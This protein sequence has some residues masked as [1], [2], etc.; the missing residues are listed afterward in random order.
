MLKVKAVTAFVPL[1]VQNL[2]AGEYKAL[3]DQLVEAVGHDNI[4]VFNDFPFEA[5]T[6]FG[7]AD[8][9]HIDPRDYPDRYARKLDMS[10]SS[11][12]QHNRTSWAMIASQ[13]QPD[14][15][16]WVWLDYGV[17]K[18]GAFTGRPV[19]AASIRDFMA[20]VAHG[21][22]DDVPY[23]GIWEERQV[24]DQD[25]N[26]RFC[27]STHI[28]PKRHLEAIH[29]TYLTEVELFLQRTGCLPYDMT[30]WAAVERTGCAPFRQYRANH[31]N[32]QFSNFTPLTGRTPL[33]ELAMKYGTDKC[34]PAK[35][36]PVYHRLLG[37]SAEQVKDVLEIGICAKR[38]IPNH[39]TGASLFMWRD[40][41]PNARI[42]G[43]D[44]DPASMVFDERIR[45]F[46]IDQSSR[47]QLHGLMKN[48]GDGFDLIVDD[49]SHNPVHQLVSLQTLLP[50]VRNGGT[51]VIEDI[52]NWMYPSTR[53]EDF[54]AQLPPDHEGV[55]YGEL[56][57]QLLVI[58]RK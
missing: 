21:S 43:I 35:Y 45:S 51:Y 33:C 4:V 14:V 55:A 37:G 49:G 7:R 16:V 31:D 39:R 3:G 19:Q 8:T 18:Q 28:W 50:Y 54:I 24:A 47:P 48:F 26:W 2:T 9:P 15:D 27:G 32:T 58:R 57:H 34:V 20:A 40:Y 22:T 5:C 44:I 11:V 41:F 17:M 12:V 30:I 10:R 1:G 42:V 25:A 38:D 29:R 23:P 53:P 56:P 13:Q 46:M 6:F 36:T 52:G